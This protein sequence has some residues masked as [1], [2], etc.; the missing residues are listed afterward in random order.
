MQNGS[1]PEMEVSGA[2]CTGD[3]L[4]ISPMESGAAETHIGLV[5]CAQRPTGAPKAMPGTPA[6]SHMAEA[7]TTV[8]D[9]IS[10]A[11]A[12]IASLTLLYS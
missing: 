6:A 4:I 1:S 12:R 5:Q 10:L 8:T 11:L 3:L 7:K 9:I 2:I